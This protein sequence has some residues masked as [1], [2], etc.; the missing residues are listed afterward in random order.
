MSAF[1]VEVVDAGAKAALK[2]LAAR[3]NN[4]QPVMQT[5]AVDITER[6]QHRFDTSSGPD[7]APWKPNSDATRAM[8]IA[9]LAGSKSNRKKDGS[10]NAKGNRA[11]ANKK[12]LID[13]GLLRQ[14][15]V[16]SS[17]PTSLTV[18]TS[19]VTGAYAAI[20]NFGGQAGRGHKVAIPAR[21]FMPM[22]QDGTLYPKESE[23]ILGEINAYLMDG[24]T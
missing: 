23:L 1:S 5:L 20:N 2:T 3:V 16:P 8:L 11:L 13:S 18:S 12:P 4:M 9:R 24:I 15:I 7:G 6:V 21:P 14:Q 19:S 10:L 22:H 17:T